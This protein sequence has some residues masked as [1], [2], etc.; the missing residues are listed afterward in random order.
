MSTGQN[1]DQDSLPLEA[2]AQIHDICN[3]FEQAFRAGLSPRIEDYLVKLN[4]SQSSRSALLLA[5]LDIELELRRARGDRP[6]TEEY[7]AL[8]GR[9]RHDRHRI[10]RRA[11]SNPSPR[12]RQRPSLHG[13]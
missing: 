7:L 5:L 13:R 8:P 10:R 2:L 4:A 12:R 3:A 9:R 11:D 1:S 6:T